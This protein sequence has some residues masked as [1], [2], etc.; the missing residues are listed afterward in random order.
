MPTNLLM[1]MP[2][3]RRLIP[4]LAL[5]CAIVFVVYV[6]LILAT[7]VFASSETR[8]SS[9]VR[10]AEDRIATMETKYY[11]AIGGIS[12]ADVSARGFRQPVKAEY[13]AAAG[14][15]AVSLAPSGV[16]NR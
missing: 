1:R 9:A 2:H 12:S 6:A 7:I 10:S 8:A 5:F 14:A 4:I 11:A 16:V 15:P 13:V 3:P